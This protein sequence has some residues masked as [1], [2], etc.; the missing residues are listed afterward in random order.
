MYASILVFLQFTLIAL[1]LFFSN[2]LSA[3]TNH[4]LAL[5]IFL[6]GL[7][8]A[9]WALNHNRIG[10]FHVRPKLKENC[11]LIT[12]GIYRFIRHPMY[13]SLILMMLSVLISSFSILEIILFLL[14]IVVLVLKALREESL[15]ECHNEEYKKYKKNSKLFIPYIL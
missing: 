12:T 6:I 14:F 4:T 5:A 7:S 8:F 3:F 9:L 13:A 2:G 15:W 10:N 1:M 11:K